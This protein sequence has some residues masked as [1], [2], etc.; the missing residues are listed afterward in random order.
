MW[1]LQHF[2]TPDLSYSFFLFELLKY[3]HF[4]GCWCTVAQ[5]TQRC[6]SPAV[7]DRSRTA[8][9]LIM[10]L[11]QQSIKIQPHL[12]VL[13]LGFFSQLANN[14]YPSIRKSLYSTMG[15]NTFPIVCTGSFR[16][17]KI[18]LNSLYMSVFMCIYIFVCVNNFLGFN[19]VYVFLHY[20]VD[21][22]GITHTQPFTRICPQLCLITKYMRYGLLLLIFLLLF[23]RQLS[24]SENQALIYVIYTWHKLWCLW[25]FTWITHHVRDSS[26]YGRWLVTAKQMQDS[27][28]NMFKWSECWQCVGSALIC[29]H[30]HA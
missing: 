21:W 30:V 24:M 23:S 18:Y 28:S 19:E 26:T 9:T 16:M 13:R 8:G 7:Q 12:L 4:R 25:Q 22:L 5:L 2:Q 27:M 1:S 20:T 11:S 17:V 10:V 14:S 15:I 6:V 29:A 3:Q